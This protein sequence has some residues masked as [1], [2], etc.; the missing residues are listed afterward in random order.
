MNPNVISDE[1][2]ERVAQLTEAEEQ[3]LERWKGTPYEIKL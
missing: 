1:W 2:V 3:L